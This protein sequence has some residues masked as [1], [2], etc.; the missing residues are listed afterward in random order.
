MFTFDE[1]SSTMPEERSQEEMTPAEFRKLK[2]KAIKQL[3]D[4]EIQT[5]QTLGM[6]QFNSGPSPFGDDIVSEE[7]FREWTAKLKNA[8]T[9]EEIAALGKEIE[10]ATNEE[11]N[12]DVFSKDQNQGIEIIV[13]EV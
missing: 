13:I 12:K 7:K 6:L 3:G 10:E 4:I 9:K 8:R 11:F 5:L 2:K 1:P